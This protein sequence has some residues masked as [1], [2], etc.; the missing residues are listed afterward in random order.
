LEELYRQDG[1]NHKSQWRSAHQNSAMN[2]LLSKLSLRRDGGRLT[3][4]LT[5]WL[6]DC[7]NRDT[8]CYIQTKDLHQNPA[9]LL[10]VECSRCSMD[11]VGLPAIQSFVWF[12][13]AGPVAMLSAHFMVLL[14][15]GNGK[16]IHKFSYVID[17]LKST[18]NA[19]ISLNF[20]F[21]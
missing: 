2:G 18:K 21:S 6:T 5:D 14:Y 17:V 16:K 20:F 13:G 9:S 8:V 1:P 4:W 7:L 11:R 10:Q 3:D 19:Y 12:F 15:S